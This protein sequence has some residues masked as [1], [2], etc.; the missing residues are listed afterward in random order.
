MNNFICASIEE[1][2]QRKGSEKSERRLQRNAEARAV[3]ILWLRKRVA[4]TELEEAD[5]KGG[6]R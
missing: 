2:Y 5:S 1:Y 6:K 3:Q 4:C